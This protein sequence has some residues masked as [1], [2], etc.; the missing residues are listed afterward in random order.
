M[1]KITSGSQRQAL[2]QQQPLFQ[3]DPQLQ[4]GGVRRALGEQG[5]VNLRQGEPDGRGV[6]RH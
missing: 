5:H 6:R 4:E 3:L 1:Q 2:L